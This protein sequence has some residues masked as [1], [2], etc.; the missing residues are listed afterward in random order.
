M[1]RWLLSAVAAALMPTGFRTR[2]V[3]VLQG[4]QLLGKT[5]W[6]LALIPD[7]L[8]RDSVNPR[9]IVHRDTINSTV[10]TG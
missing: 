8:L 7:S 3:L 6:F 4:R 2:G 5:S 1:Y 9:R 10:F